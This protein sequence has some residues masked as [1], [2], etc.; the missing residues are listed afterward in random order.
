[1]KKQVMLLAF[2]LLSL[3]N[4]TNFET[5]GQGQSVDNGKKFDFCGYDVFGNSGGVHL[6]KDQKKVDLIHISREGFYTGD[7]GGTLPVGPGKKLG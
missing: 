5:G 4:P 6:P 1:M 7:T 2:G 3:T